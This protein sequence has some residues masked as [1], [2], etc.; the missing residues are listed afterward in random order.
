MDKASSTRRRKAGNVVTPLEL[1]DGLPS[2]ESFPDDDDDEQQ[3]RRRHKRRRRKQ[4]HDEE[5][6]SFL[7]LFLRTGTVIAFLWLSSWS[8]YRHFVPYR[9]PAVVSTVLDDDDVI[10]YS[11]ARQAAGAVNHAVAQN[12][13]IPP[14][15]TF[16]I[17]PR[18]RLWDAHALARRRTT[19]SSPLFWEEAALIRDNFTEWYGGDEVTARA[20]LDR[21]LTRYSNKDNDKSDVMPRDLQHTACRLMRAKQENRPF[22]L[23]FAG[24][25][26]TVGR[27]NYFHQSYP[28]VLERIMH[29]VF[30]QAGISLQVRNAAIGGCPAFPYGW[31]LSNF[32]G[33]HP[34]VI[35]WDFAMNEAGGDPMGLEAYL[36]RAWYDL[37][38]PPPQIIVR[39]THLAVERRV[40]LQN[41]S[42]WFPDALT[43]HTDPAAAVYLK[44]P[45]T[46]RP[47][48]FREWRKFGSP[49]GAP[50][51]ALHHP[52]VAE[53]RLMAHL[54]AMH[55]LAALELVMLQDELQAT[56]PLY[57]SC[58]DEQK[59]TLP[60]PWT[61]SETTATPPWQSLFVGDASKDWKM[62]DIA[63]RTSFEPII[64]GDLTPLVVS[65]SEGED[66]DILKPRS[67]MFYNKGWTLDLAH[68]EKQAKKNLLRYGGLGFIDSKKAYYGIEM[69]GWIRMILPFEKSSKVKPEKSDLANQWFRSVVICEVNDKTTTSR[70]NDQGPRCRFDQDV[71]FLIGGINATASVKPVTAGGSLYLGKTVCY[72]LSVPTGARLVTASDLFEKAAK[73][74]RARIVEQNKNHIESRQQALDPMV[75][76]PNRDGTYPT[77]GLPVEVKVR[78]P[79]IFHVERA[80]S[81]AHV[82]WEHA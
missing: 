71:E 46:Y 17:S 13:T 1:P 73:D 5:E 59:T 41:Y 16:D 76:L 51:Q 29:Y 69:S 79:H 40:L 58:R 31:C 28:L 37:G 75:R 42:R 24:Y 23:A 57:L 65:G 43:M 78:N 47:R 48:G 44:L 30:V 8:V 3:R 14:L 55:Y 50:G 49:R 7:C 53:H 45:E 39:D 34:D 54:L 10:Y 66:L 33:T 74:T 19:F 21:G 27:G 2:I 68:E 52:A 22:V 61:W 56:D 9:D 18:T 81:I 26:V 38:S 67:K 6:E 11:N 77:L 80:C 4:S 20:L 36:R 12:V 64:D 62:T 72:H 82:V 60:A 15:P 32:L 35:S 70:A 25:S 63:C